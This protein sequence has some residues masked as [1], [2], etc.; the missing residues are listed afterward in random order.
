MDFIFGLPKT[1]RYFDSIYVVIDRLSKMVHFILCK[2]ATDASYTTNL[3]IK[4]VVKLHG[5]SR[6]LTSNRDIKFISHFWRIL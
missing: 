5:V 4:E 3:F 1:Q 2:K 6:S